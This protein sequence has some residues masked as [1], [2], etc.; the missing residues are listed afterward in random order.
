VESPAVTANSSGGNGQGAGDVQINAASQVYYRI[1]VRVAG[2]K[3]T[4]SYV[5]SHVA[6]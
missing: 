1:T 3:R 6:M 5:Q 2:P 4:E